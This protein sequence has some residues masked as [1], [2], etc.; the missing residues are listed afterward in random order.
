MQNFLRH[1][2]PEVRF[3]DSKECEN[4]MVPEHARRNCKSSSRQQIATNLA[5]K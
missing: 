3:E 5:I 2:D 1:K 4:V